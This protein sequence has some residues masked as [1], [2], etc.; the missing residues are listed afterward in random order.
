MT[1]PRISSKSASLSLG[2]TP[3]LRNIDV[4][5]DAGEIVGCLGPSGAGKSTLFRALVGD[6]SLDSGKVHLEGQDVTAWP[7]WR[8]ARLGLS[9]MPQGP[10]LLPDLTVQEN[11]ETFRSIGR[12]ATGSVH[13]A[14]SQVGLE[15]RLSSRAGALSAGE[16]RRL[17]LARALTR[18]P[19]V[20]VCD[21]PFAGVDPAAAER[22]ARHLQELAQS[23]V[24]ILFADHHVEES[25][26]ICTRALLLLD[27]TIAAE[28]D[29][30]TFRTLPLVQGRY[31]GSWART[32]PPTSGEA[33]L[34]PR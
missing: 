13:E 8:R 6:L 26:R 16:R 24:G 1:T 27:G 4:H 10:S 25:L 18:T 15:T 11:L 22:L 12:V 14:A 29:P 20:L 32:F 31:L 28:A 21:E 33:H 30:R 2:G 34:T 5:V 19:K 23:G 3:L 17:E 7:L 9:Y